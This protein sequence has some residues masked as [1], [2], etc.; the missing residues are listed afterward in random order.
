MTHIL[1]SALPRLTRAGATAWRVATLLPFSYGGSGN[2]NAIGPSV[3]LP[4]ISSGLAITGA[5]GVFIMLASTSFKASSRPLPSLI[6]LPCQLS[7]SAILLKPPPLRVL[8]ITQAGLP[9]TF[10][11]CSKA[12][13]T[14]SMSCPSSTTI[15][16]QPNASTF[17][18]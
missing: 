6:G 8:A 3:I 1:S 15:A 4:T 14:C 12:L 7:W 9:L 13:T 2:C 10:K 17:L 18:A 16:S 11:A 5:G